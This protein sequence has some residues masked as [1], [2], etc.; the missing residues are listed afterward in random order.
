MAS[1]NIDNNDLQVNFSQ[2]DISSLVN[3][4]QRDF[5]SHFPSGQKVKFRAEI[6][7]QTLTTTVPKSWFSTK[8][9]STLKHKEQQYCR[10]L[11]CRL[12]SY[13]GEN[14]LSVEVIAKS[15][16]EDMDC[17]LEVLNALSQEKRNQVFKRFLF[18]RDEEGTK[19]KETE[20][21]LLQREPGREMH[22]FNTKGNA[23]KPEQ[24]LFIPHIKHVAE[25]LYKQPEV[26]DAIKVHM[27]ANLSAEIYQAIVQHS[28]YCIVRIEAEPSPEIMKW[29]PLEYQNNLIERARCSKTISSVAVIKLI[30][31]LSE[32]QYIKHRL[33]LIT[34]AYKKQLEKPSPEFFDE[35]KALNISEEWGDYHELYSFLIG[36]LETNAQ[37]VTGLFCSLPETI[38]K[39]HLESFLW[40]LLKS[41]YASLINNTRRLV[42][43]CDAL[44]VLLRSSDVHKS[45]TDDEYR[46]FSSFIYEVYKLDS[47]G[48]CQ[49]IVSSLQHLSH[50]QIYQ[51][52]CKGLALT[53]HQQLMGLILT[54]PENLSA[55]NLPKT[56][57]LFQQH[58]TDR[59]EFKNKLP[60]V[61]KHRLI[62]Y[63]TDNVNS[64]KQTNVQS[65][66]LLPIELFND[67]LRAPLN[68][69]NYVDLLTRIQLLEDYPQ[70]MVL[71]ILVD[72]FDYVSLHQI[73]PN[74]LIRVVKYFV[75]QYAARQP[76]FVEQ[77]VV[78]QDPVCIRA[79]VD[80]EFL[81]LLLTT[82][83]ALISPIY[84][85][86]KP[87]TVWKQLQILPAYINEVHQFVLL[88]LTE[89]ELPIRSVRVGPVTESQGEEYDYDLHNL[90]QYAKITEGN[91]SI[92][93]DFIMDK[94]IPDR[95]NLLLNLS[96]RQKHQLW[97]Q[98]K[99]DNGTKQ[100]ALTALMSCF[101]S[102][103]DRIR[104]LQGC[105]SQDS[106]QMQDKIVELA[107]SKVDFSKSV[108]QIALSHLQKLLLWLDAQ[109]QQLLKSKIGQYAKEL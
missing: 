32:E 66:P 68:G 40:L 50:S 91:W 33:S 44:A 2:V 7:S 105:E 35:I 83:A 108:D 21:K 19:S 93:K 11:K 17:F 38:K 31:C 63:F 84:R 24:V 25:Y 54:S 92:W 28:L 75:E 103:A 59:E 5:I 51:L 73:D 43:D 67:L 102:P 29:L 15:L 85:H 56:L 10:Q 52:F 36:Q 14:E 89:P 90:L 94:N 42:E 13:Q 106:A 34:V 3:Q 97:A 107:V 86:V 39:Q 65:K 62:R 22:V 98:I 30:N 61:L 53:K 18:C 104:F 100:N 37:E 70:E 76:N 77:L 81:K 79:M 47:A 4:G 57:L 9:P 8:I 26:Y 41:N 64:K 6:Q 78:V 45:L 109:H 20:L 99:Q 71:K 23:A 60:L 80:D 12:L 1:V 49:T 46:R 58:D 16:Y 55:E 48:C 27:D 87:Q 88:G 74:S 96:V 95:H 72:A 82:H 101:K 69:S